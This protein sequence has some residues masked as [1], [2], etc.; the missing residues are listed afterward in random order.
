MQCNKKKYIIPSLRRPAKAA[1]VDNFSSQL[2]PVLN[3]PDS[4][5]PSAKHGYLT[6]WNK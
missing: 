2:K 3:R 5:Y 1:T 4:S 6:P